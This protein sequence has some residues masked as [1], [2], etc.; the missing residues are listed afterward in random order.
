MTSVSMKF[1][2]RSKEENGQK[3]CFTE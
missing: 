3:R 2:I 1:M